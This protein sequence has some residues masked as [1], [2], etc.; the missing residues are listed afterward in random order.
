MPLWTMTPTVGSNPAQMVP[1]NTTVTVSYTVTNNSNNKSIPGG[2]R[3]L[4]IWPLQGITQEGQ[5]IV[6]PRDSTTATYTLT[7]T[8]NGSQLPSGGVS[9]GPA[10]C[11]ANPDGSPNPS[12]C[13]V[14]CGDSSLNIP[15]VR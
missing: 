5:C 7:M 4:V 13:Y 3:R 10:L 9:G 14:S 15:V 6:G 1:E 12:Q 2:I 11:Q 8:I